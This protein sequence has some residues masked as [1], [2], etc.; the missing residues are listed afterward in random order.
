MLQSHGRSGLRSG[1]AGSLACTLVLAGCASAPAGREG[2][3]SVAD[4]P[5]ESQCDESAKRAVGLGPWVRAAGSGALGM[6]LGAAWGAADG[7][8][9]GFVRGVNSGQA[10][11]IG[12]AAG[13]GIGLLIGLVAGAAKGR[14][15]PAVYRSAYYSCL[16]GGAPAPEKTALAENAHET[17][18][19]AWSE[20]ER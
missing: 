19:A 18:G 7:A 4:T 5:R 3:A 10:A 8:S 17:E 14:E 11:W 2:M 13:A 9:W 6:I 16:A 15:A 20:S 1:V 12:A